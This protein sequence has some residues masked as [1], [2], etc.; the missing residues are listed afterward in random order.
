MNYQRALR[1]TVADWLHV[2]ASSDMK[3]GRDYMRYAQKPVEITTGRYCVLKLDVGLDNGRLL[4]LLDEP[5]VHQLMPWDVG[6]GKPQVYLDRRYV[7]IEAPLPRHAQNTDVKLHDL[8]GNHHGGRVALLGPNETGVTVS[9]HLQDIIHLLIGGQTGAGKTYTMRSLARQFADGRNQ[10]VLADGKRG[11]GLGILNGLP[12]QVG[13]LAVDRQTMID[14]LGW[15]HDEMT[16]RYDAVN[17]R[18]G[19][20]WADGEPSAPPHVLVFFDEFQVY[21]DDAAVMTLMHSLVAQGRSARI[22]VIAGTQRP[23][24]KMFGRDVGGATRGQFGTRIAHCV[25][26]YKSS[27]AIVGD[28]EPRADYLL[29]QGDSYILGSTGNYPLRERVQIA[30]VPEVDLHRFA[31]GQPELEQWPEYK[32]D[33]PDGGRGRLETQFDNAQL[34]CAVYAAR[35]G[36][37]R[38]RLQN[39]LDDMDASISGSVP[40]DRLL[41]DG[42]EIQDTLDCL[43]KNNEAL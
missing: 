27:E 24:V 40:A 7:A 38:G 42:R 13:P 6:A 3:S 14:S 30:Y 28:S 25:N 21:R 11:D 35:Q 9:L 43:T 36:W 22:H 41:A 37:G 4:K 20:A 39:L 32:G 26:G 29:M 12:G 1:K 5:T 10:I 2:I 34:G 8:S 19:L 23:T 31:G 16:K 33:L 17:Q 15:T 18:G